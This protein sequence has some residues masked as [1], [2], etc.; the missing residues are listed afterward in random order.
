MKESV[1]AYH[2]GQI[3]A[4]LKTNQKTLVDDVAFQIRAGETLSLVGETGS[5]KT[6]IALSVMKLLPSNVRMVGGSVV[7]LGKELP[8]EKKMKDLLGSEIVYIPQNG[9]EALNPSRRVDQHLYDNLLKIGVRKADLKKT[10]EDKLRA[11]GFDR[12][13]QILDKYPFQLSGGMAQRVTIAISACSNARLIIADEPTNGLD[14]GSKAVFM[15]MLR[16]LFPM[17]AKLIITHDISIAEMCDQ[18]L[19]LCG[20]RM[21]ERGF[22]SRVLGSPHHPYTQALLAALAKNGLKESPYLRQEK[23]FCTFYRR[24]PLASDRCLTA[25]EHQTEEESDWWCNHVS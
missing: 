19:V 14:Q 16:R 23:G 20:G 7:F 22:S 25:M 12:P 13:D 15:A 4:A 6:M 8:G 9:L 2:S 1:L 10:A 3:I 17:A 18:S 24:C 5:G 11:V 21:M